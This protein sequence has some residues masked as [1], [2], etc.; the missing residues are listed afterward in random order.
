[1]VLD[2]FQAKKITYED[3]KDYIPMSGS[4]IIDKSRALDYLYL[5][6]MPIKYKSD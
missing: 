5:D 1:M 3:I 6:H 4:G 2:F